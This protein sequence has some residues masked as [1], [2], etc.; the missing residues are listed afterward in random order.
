[1]ATRTTHLDWQRTE[2][3][4]PEL[5][6]AGTTMVTAAAVILA[7]WKL[8]PALML[9]VAS[10]VLLLAGFTVALFFWRRSPPAGQLSYR[11]VAGM[12]VF[13]GFAAALLTDTSALGP[14]WAAGN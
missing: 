6:L 3:H 13:F 1:M 10:L 14:L 11:D 7:L 9:P 12:L 2:P 8:S 5:V 4:G